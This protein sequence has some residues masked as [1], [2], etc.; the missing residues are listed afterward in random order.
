MGQISPRLRV[1]AEGVV[2]RV[3]GVFGGDFESC[4]TNINRREG[5]ICN[6]KTEL[7]TKIRKFRDPTVRVD[8]FV[9]GHLHSS[10]VVC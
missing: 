8:E 5:A 9:S 6:T 4:L 2:E 1:E 3:T 7:A 10:G